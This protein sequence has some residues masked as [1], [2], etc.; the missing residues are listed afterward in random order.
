[1]LA[2]APSGRGGRVVSAGYDHSVV[3]W[4][5]ESGAVIATLVGYSHVVEAVD[6]CDGGPG[7]AALAAAL[8]AR[9]AA[10]GRRTASV[11]SL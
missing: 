9:A 1:M 4:N 2:V 10:G 3:V 5:V 8:R 6:A 7:E 11:A